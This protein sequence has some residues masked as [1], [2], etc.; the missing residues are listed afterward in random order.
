M[1]TACLGLIFSLLI[2]FCCFDSAT[3]AQ[4]EPSSTELQILIHAGKGPPPKRLGHSG[5]LYFDTSSGND[6]VLYRRSAKDDW[7]K[8]GVL[9]INNEP[10]SGEQTCKAG[11]YVIGLTSQGKIVC[12]T[13]VSSG[14]R[15]GGACSG[16][17]SLV[18]TQCQCSSGWSGS[19]CDER[20]K[21]TTEDIAPNKDSDDDGS[22]IPDACNDHDDEIY[23]GAAEIP[24]GKDNNCN[25]LV[26]EP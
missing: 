24:D 23:P 18:D 25:G 3:A 26:D 16:H 21:L 15:A 9:R 13:T 2:A 22:S 8:S 1:H 4:V 10:A 12:G 11:Q 19:A 20:I 17:G 7:D 5:D 14:S 6:H